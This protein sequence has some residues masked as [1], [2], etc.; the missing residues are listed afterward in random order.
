MNR[1]ERRVLN[2]ELTPSGL[3]RKVMFHLVRWGLLVALAVLT[4]VMYPVARSFDVP[5]YEVGQVATHDVIAPDTFSVMKS[6]EEIERE[7]EA[8]A[9]TV[10]PI[11]EYR[12][13][14]IE[15][16]LR[17]SDSLFAALSAA[18]SAR[19]MIAAASPFGVRLTAE[20]AEYLRGRGRIARFRRA[21]VAHVQRYLS[22]GVPTTQAFDPEQTRAIVVRR[23]ESEREIHRDS[24]ISYQR[25]I[26]E[27]SVSAPDP[28]APVAGIA[29]AKLLIGVFHPTLVPNPEETE[30][31][32]NELRASV[33]SVKYVVQGDEGIVFANRVV[34]PEQRERLLALRQRILQRGSGARSNV[35][36]IVGQVLTNVMILTVFWLLLMLHRRHTYD[37]LRHMLV[38][39]GLFAVVILVAAAN[40]QLISESRPELIPIPYAAL[41]IAVVIGGRA[42]MLAAIVLAILLG[43]QVAYGG[44]DAVIIA[45]V[46]G[47]AAAVSVQAIRRRSQL[48]ASFVWVTAAYLAAAVVIGLGQG[49]PLV[50]LGMTGLFG[51]LNAFLSAALVVF[52]LPIL[53]SLARVTTDLTLLELSDPSRPLLRRLATEAPGTYAHSVAM[54][55]LCES[56]CNSIGANGLLARV[57]CYYHDVGKLKKPQF[58]VENQTSGMNPHDR[59]KPD[60]SAGIIRN[61]V[62]DGLALAEEY[63]IPDAVR[64]FIPEHHGTMEISY[65]LDRARRRNGNDDVEPAEFRYPGPK[66]RSVETAVAMLADGV[67]AALRVLDNPTPEKV[68]HA[69]EHIVE[70]RIDAG[71]LE[72]APLTLAQMARVKQEFA[73]VLG[74]VY[75]NRIDY[76]AT[77]GGIGAKWEA[78]AD[79]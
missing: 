31:R 38:L 41:M 70:Q 30:R 71:Q 52:T 68:T 4:Y 24:V 40:H 77:S 34:T 51:G 21:V 58:F 74:G 46:G 65:F 75:H 54:A 23:G 53:E 59:L 78:H 3:P 60:V 5:L 7:A 16:T 19:E 20:E 57:G 62:K 43:S 13:D 73:R 32:R 33:D 61:H 49:Q 37:D 72:E 66:P 56:T 42:A 28:D 6:S 18:S 29:F 50:E 79:A 14:S 55:N 35:G 25:Y 15:A 1:P 10:L 36:G 27:R 45:L 11:Y 12:T 26:D 8:L 2:L 39:A 64:A 67:E 44:I 17:E 63:K 69:I 9:A 22:R 47:V 76:P 48:I